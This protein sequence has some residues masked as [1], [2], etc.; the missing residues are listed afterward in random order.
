LAKGARRQ[1][2]RAE[3]ILSWIMHHHRDERKFSVPA[4]NYFKMLEILQVLRIS[5]PLTFGKLR[6]SVRLIRTSE[7]LVMYLGVLEQLKFISQQK[8]R[9][10][11]GFAPM[12]SQISLTKNGGM[13]LATIDRVAWSEPVANLPKSSDFVDFS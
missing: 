9:T 12:K 6:E 3:D 7:H 5:G 2:S 13:F 11:G 1:F 4:L 8:K 10:G